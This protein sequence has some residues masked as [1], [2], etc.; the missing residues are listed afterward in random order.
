MLPRKVRAVVTTRHGCSER[1]DWHIEGTPEAH[2][3]MH[4]LIERQT[5]MVCIGWEQHPDNQDED[6][7]P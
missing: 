2:D 6:D 1:S 5:E 7:L 4:S 3:A